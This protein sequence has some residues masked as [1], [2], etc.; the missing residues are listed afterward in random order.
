MKIVNLVSLTSLF[1]E[2]NSRKSPSWRWRQSL[3]RS[4]GRFFAE[5]LSEGSLV[6][7]GLLDPSTGVGLRYGRQKHKFTIFSGQN[8]TQ[9]RHPEGHLSLISCSQE[10]W[11]V[12]P[13]NRSG[14]IP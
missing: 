10:T 12:K 6:G 5:F 4:Y 8:F 3:F 14:H 9:N 1:A 7:L 13:L 2:A 11:T